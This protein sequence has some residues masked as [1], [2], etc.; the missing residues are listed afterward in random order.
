MK[1]QNIAYTQSEQKQWV[2]GSSLKE[3]RRN[4]DVKEIWENSWREMPQQV[5]GFN[6]KC[7]IRTGLSRNLETGSTSNR[8]ESVVGLQMLL[9]VDIFVEN[10]ER[11][12]F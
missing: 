4:T 9:S 10:R 2:H 3:R 6:D 8:N 12:L 11:I 7:C 1:S 5:K